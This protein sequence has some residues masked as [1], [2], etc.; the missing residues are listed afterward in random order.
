MSNITTVAG[1]KSAIRFLEVEQAS[2][3]N[4]FKEQLS[5]LY[6]SLKPINILKNTL[7]QVF[8]TQNQIDNFSGSALG[9]VSG[10]LLKQLFFGKSNN[11]FSRLIG[12]ILQMSISNIVTQNS[13]YI[14][15]VGE[16]LIKYFFHRKP[17]STRSHVS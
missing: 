7:K 1:L 5:L 10:L 16:G 8:S 4:L 17:K 13:D 15:S 3:G 2:K 12:S 14:K 6:E 11:K 9:V